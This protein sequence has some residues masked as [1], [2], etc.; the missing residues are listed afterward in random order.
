MSKRSEPEG[1]ELLIDDKPLG[2]RPKDRL[3]Q[4]L[5]FGKLKPALGQYTNSPRPTYTGFECKPTRRDGLD[6]ASLAAAMLE[7]SNNSENRTL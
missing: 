4:K 6:L 3:S 1:R 2:R 7:P 5:K